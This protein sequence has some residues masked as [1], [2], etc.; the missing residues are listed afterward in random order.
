LF[1]EGV[2]C[3]QVPDVLELQELQGGKEMSA[4]WEAIDKEIAGL[5]EREGVACFP[6][7]DVVKRTMLRGGTIESNDEWQ[8]DHLWWLMDDIGSLRDCRI[9]EVGAGVGGFAKAVDSFAY[10]IH[11]LP[12][13]RKIQRENGCKAPDWN[14]ERPDLIVSLWALSE[15]DFEERKI[16][17]PMSDAA[18]F[19]AFQ[20]RHNG[21]NNLSWFLLHGI[22]MGRRFVVEPV[23]GAEG[24]FYMYIEGKK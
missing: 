22:R 19:Y 17:E 10:W 11:D 14:G 13:M 24:S 5:I 23:A 9:L 18:Q 1:E 8:D 15:M 6:R 7:W 2:L 21:M 20:G 12:S 16:V 4:E 3:G